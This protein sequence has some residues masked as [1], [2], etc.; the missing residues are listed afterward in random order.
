LPL[1]LIFFVCFDYNE[2]PAPNRVNTHLVVVLSSAATETGATSTCEALT[3][4]AIN[5]S[6]IKFALP[7]ASAIKLLSSEGTVT[8]NLTLLPDLP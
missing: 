3:P 6:T 4:F 5:T 2:S 7:S 8:D 1:V